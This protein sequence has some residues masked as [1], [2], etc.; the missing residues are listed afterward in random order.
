MS[1]SVSFDRPCEP[2]LLLVARTA[3][4][5]WAIWSIAVTPTGWF[6]CSAS[7]SEGDL[8]NVPKSIG[9]KLAEIRKYGL[10]INMVG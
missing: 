10:F 3:S 4:A 7:H 9:P 5:M 8:N 1:S 6:F 2:G